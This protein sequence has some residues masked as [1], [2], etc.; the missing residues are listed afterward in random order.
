LF[1]NDTE[2][3]KFQYWYLITS[4]YF[5]IK[6]KKNQYNGIIIENFKQTITG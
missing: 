1:D 5:Q 2:K 4:N 3:N 6:A